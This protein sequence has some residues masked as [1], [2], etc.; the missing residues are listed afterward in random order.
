MPK[1]VVVMPAYNAAKTIEYTFRSI[2]GNCIDEVILVDYGS[3]GSLLHFAVAYGGT[4]DTDLKKRT[5]IPRNAG[6]SSIRECNQNPF[7]LI[8]GGFGNSGVSYQVK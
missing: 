2:P 1:T 4:W 7:Y 8:S 3:S 6:E 5:S